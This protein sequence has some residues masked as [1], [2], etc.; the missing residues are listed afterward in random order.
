M[1]R[2]ETNRDVAKALW[3]AAYDLARLEVR[4]RNRHPETIE[5]PE[6]QIMRRDYLRLIKSYRKHLLAE[7]EA[8]YGRSDTAGDYRGRD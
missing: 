8:I 7:A 5:L 2:G 1:P 3:D 4:I 6:Y